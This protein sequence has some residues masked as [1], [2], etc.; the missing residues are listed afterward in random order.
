MRPLSLNVKYLFQQ[1]MLLATI[2]SI[3]SCVTPANNCHLRLFKVSA[4][5]CIDAC[6]RSH[7][8]ENLSL[9]DE[10][11]DFFDDAEAYCVSFYKTRKCCVRSYCKGEVETAAKLHGIDYGECSERLK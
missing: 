1:P 4:D 8:V 9:D 6:I 2:L 3:T 7:I 5:Y 11:D 10:F